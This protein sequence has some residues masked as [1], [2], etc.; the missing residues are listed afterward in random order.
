VGSVSASGDEIPNLAFLLP[1][2]SG[3]LTASRR[4]E[5]LGWQRRKQPLML[6]GPWGWE[7]QII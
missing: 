5:F 6:A 3:I 1:E 7:E 2:I 4:H